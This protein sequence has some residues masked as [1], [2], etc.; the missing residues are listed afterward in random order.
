MSESQRKESKEIGGANA[1]NDIDIEFDIDI[2]LHQRKALARL[3]RINSA[4]ES[5][6]SGNRI[7]RKE[8]NPPLDEQTP[9]NTRNSKRS[10]DGVEKQREQ[11]EEMA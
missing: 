11:E 3:N 6:I 4:M 1:N 5:V 7:Q 9:N 10:S 8:S 2:K